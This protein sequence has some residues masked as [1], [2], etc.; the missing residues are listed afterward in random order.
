[1]NIFYLGLLILELLHP[2]FQGD[3]IRALKNSYYIILRG[4]WWSLT[5]N[6]SLKKLDYDW[7][8][9][10]KEVGFVAHGLGDYNQINDLNVAYQSAKKGAR[11]LEVDLFLD[12]N[13]ILRCHHGPELPKP[14]KSDD[15][16]FNKLI[17]FI[18]K[19]HSFLILDIK[20]KFKNSSD[21]IYKQVALQKNSD[22]L[23]KKIIFQLM[24]PMDIKTFTKMASTSR[25]TWSAPILTLHRTHTYFDVVKDRKPDFINAITISWDRRKEIT[26]GKELI[27][28]THPMKSCTDFFQSKNFG[29]HAVYGEI[30]LFNCTK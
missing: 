29:F 12:D 1:M 4:E 27:L 14:Y 30:N 21:I 5:S 17:N 2:F 13:N 19:N 24:K 11:F 28:M 3:L 25:F 8:S 23:A 26:L 6:Y 10:L 16:D 18:N 9:K 7:Q 15:C 20:N 22:D